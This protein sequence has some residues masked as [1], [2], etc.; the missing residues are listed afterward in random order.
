[1]VIPYIDD[2]ISPTKKV[3]TFGAINSNSGEYIWHRDFHDRRILVLDCGSDWKLQLDNQ[4]P[5]DIN[6]YDKLFIP[7]MEYHRLIMGKDQL[8]IL[9]EEVL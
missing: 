7:K 5:K 1:M 4:L 6:R 9:I 2:I 8:K 3:R